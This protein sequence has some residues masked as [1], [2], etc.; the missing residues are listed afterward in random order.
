M[1]AE[2][3]DGMAVSRPHYGC[4][5]RG[6]GGGAIRVAA[7]RRLARDVGAFQG[8]V[9]GGDAGRPQAWGEPRVWA[10]GLPRGRGAP[11]RL[12]SRAPAS[13]ASR[14]VG[15]VPRGSSLK[16]DGLPECWR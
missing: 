11:L 12:S 15:A 1:A 6:S 8:P 7:K 4:E 2:D 13:R 3:V 5:Y 14:E 10:A 9:L 16:L